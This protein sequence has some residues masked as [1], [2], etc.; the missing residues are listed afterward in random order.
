MIVYGQMYVR[1]F[2]VLGLIE[3]WGVYYMTAG[4]STAEYV[5]PT[6]LSHPV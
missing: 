5:P 1:S 4:T 6:C 3:F 2:F